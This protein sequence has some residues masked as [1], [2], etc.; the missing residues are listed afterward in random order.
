M[1]IKFIWAMRNIVVL[2][3]A[4]LTLTGTALADNFMRRTL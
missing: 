3:V 4:I 2:G 1:K